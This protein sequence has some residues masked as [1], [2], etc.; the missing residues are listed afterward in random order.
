MTDIL[1]IETFIG[2]RCSELGL[3]QSEFIRDVGYK[4]ISKGIRRLEQLYAGDVSKAQKLIQALPA[5]LAVSAD[6]VNKAVEGTQ[7]QLRESKQQLRE[8]ENKAWRRLFKPHAIIL[9]ERN[10]PEPMFVAGFIGVNRI[11]RVDFDLTTGRSSYIHQALNGIGQKLAEWKCRTLPA[12]G[13]PTGV[14]VNYTPD[15]AVVF[16]LEGKALEILPR[17]YRLDDI[18]LMVGGRHVS[19]EILDKIISRG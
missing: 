13:R 1:A 2:N 11:L 19:P 9:T 18:Q 4:D 3:S 16:N 7:Q 15:R 6:A 10:R 14:V 8:S 5:M 17:A 12:F